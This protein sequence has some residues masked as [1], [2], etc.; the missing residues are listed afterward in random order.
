MLKKY[1][2]L[3]LLLV[4]AIA[5]SSCGVN[6]AQAQTQVLPPPP[7]L[8]IYDEGTRLDLSYKLNFTGAGITCTG[9]AS[10]IIACAVA[11]GAG[12]TTQTIDNINATAATGKI[13]TAAVADSGTNVGTIINNS[14]ALTGT[15]KLLSVRNNNVEKFAVGQDGSLTCGGSI[16]GTYNIGGTPTLTADLVGSSGSDITLANDAIVTARYH[17]S[18]G[19]APT[20][21]MGAANGSGG[22]PAISVSGSSEAGTV[23]ITTGSGSTGGGGAW[24]T[25]TNAAAYAFPAGA[26]M[27]ITS[28]DSDAAQFRRNFSV[29]S[30]DSCSCTT[31]VCTFQPN[32]GTPVVST[33]YVWAYEIK[34]W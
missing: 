33:Q 32:V 28:V 18:N 34:G 21:A 8:R 12:G 30:A 3:A 23:T 13:L 9:P 15:T 5:Q 4:S 24:F 20:G 27:H 22:S 10:G 31:T 6:E 17:L 2:L 14:T 16:T 29:D 25:L 11:T 7:P 26:I 19:A 1:F